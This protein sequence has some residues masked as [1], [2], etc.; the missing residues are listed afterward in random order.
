MGDW[1]SGDGCA[2][3]SSGR[4]RSEPLV[5]AGGRGGQERKWEHIEG[6]RMGVCAWRVG[7]TRRPGWLETSR[8][9][10]GRWATR[11]SGDCAERDPAQQGG[12]RGGE[13]M[14]RSGFWLQWSPWICCRGAV[15]VTERGIL[16]DGQV[17][18][19]GVSGRSRLRWEGSRQTRFRE[20]RN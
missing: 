12:S 9:R 11:E 8:V 17:P 5:G 20:T 15:G 1:L 6:P 18:G 13:E 4:R 3:K 14:R 2:P 19:K 10:R 7:A 16:D